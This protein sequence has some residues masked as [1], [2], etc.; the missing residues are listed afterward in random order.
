VAA[1]ELAVLREGVPCPRSPHGLARWPMQGKGK[2]PGAS[3]AQRGE[4]RV[5]SG[6]VGRGLRGRREGSTLSPRG[7]APSPDAREGEGA[8]SVCGA[9]ER[10]AVVGFL[11]S[12]RVLT[13]TPKQKLSI[14]VLASSHGDGV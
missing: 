5:R 7:L 3:A 1:S 4:E 13:D 12:V 11:L 6:R 2:E 10:D 9:E 8:G 14:A